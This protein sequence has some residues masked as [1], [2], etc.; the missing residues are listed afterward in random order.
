MRRLGNGNI[1]GVTPKAILDCGCGGGRNIAALLERFPEASATGLDYS[2]VSV[3]KTRQVNK[4][5][6]ESGRCNVVQGDVSAL[7]LMIVPLIW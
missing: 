1:K 4:A 6:I 3:E 7:P 2:D 5:A